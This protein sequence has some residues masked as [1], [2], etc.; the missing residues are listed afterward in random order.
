MKFQ[1]SVLNDKGT[2]KPVA[3]VEADYF[4]EKPGRTESK[5]LSS[6]Q[7]QVKF[8]LKPTGWFDDE[9]LVA[10]LVLNTPYVIEQVGI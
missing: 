8:L 1:V 7:V 6:F 2:K 4:E 3:T 5:F 9:V 10:S